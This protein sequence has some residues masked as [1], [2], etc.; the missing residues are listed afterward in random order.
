[1]SGCYAQHSVSVNATRWNLLY[2]LSMTPPTGRGARSQQPEDIAARER[3]AAWAKAYSDAVV[4]GV[5]HYRD[6][7]GMRNSDLMARL[8]QLG[9]TVTSNTLAGIL[10]KK[11]TSMPVTDVMLFA[12]A[13]NVPPAALLFSTHR[14]EELRLYPAATRT[15]PPYQAVKW[16]SGSS[17]LPLAAFDDHFVDLVDDYYEVGDIVART[18]EIDE[19][20]RAFRDLHAGLLA[21]EQRGDDVASALDQAQAA[22]EV[23]AERRRYLRV[24]HPE[25]ALPSVRPALAFVD[26]PKRNWPALPLVEFTTDHELRLALRGQSATPQQRADSSEQLDQLEVSRK[27]LLEGGTGGEA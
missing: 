13:L 5:L 3:L 11:R 24:F 1:M 18:E 9:W 21:A 20:A 27:K 8:D 26:Q 16:F 15:V 14:A 17:A 23:L 12:A 7:R 19:A 6:K 22:L 25:A 2:G 4:D 10:S